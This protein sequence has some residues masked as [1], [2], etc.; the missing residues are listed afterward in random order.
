MGLC[1][2]IVEK[3]SVFIKIKRTLLG[4]GANKMEEKMKCP[5]CQFVQ[6]K[7]PY[8]ANCGVNV[9]DYDKKLSNRIN[10]IIKNPITQLS[11]LIVFISGS[12]F[13]FQ[14][15][16]KPSVNRN[17][18]SHKKVKS[19]KRPTQSRQ[20]I[21]EKKFKTQISVNPK[22]GTSV[23]S[24]QRTNNNKIPA[25]FQSV[26]MT[27]AIVSSN[28]LFKNKKGQQKIPISLTHFLK[29]HRVEIIKTQ[30]IA[31]SF[32]DITHFSFIQNINLRDIAS[33]NKNN[34]IQPSSD[35][36]SENS[37]GSLNNGTLNNG[38]LNEQNSNSIKSTNNDISSES[39]NDSFEENGINIGVQILNSNNNLKLKIN[40][41]YFFQS[42]DTEPAE[43]E[44]QGEIALTPD[45]V[46]YYKIPF[47]TQTLSS[48]VSEAFKSSPLK[49]LINSQGK[50]MIIFFEGIPNGG[51]I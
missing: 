29:Q 43:T 36:I 2:S 40:T 28:Y 25:S 31:I 19:I 6:P 10:R 14:S 30:N 32:T 34:S 46:A 8:C 11:L 48:T 44:I 47:P 50:E 24:K 49:N 39:E 21:K 12:F 42:S 51:S 33:T 4:F 3:N 15:L 1:A 27:L 22:R 23:F 17:I 35:E 13:W 7:D 18:S 9:S 26:K 5:K 20:Q 45:S 38:A 37:N 16:Q 41:Q